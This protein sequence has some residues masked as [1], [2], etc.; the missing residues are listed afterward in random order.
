MQVH[1]LNFDIL[2]LI[3][4]LGQRRFKSQTGGPKTWWFN[5]LHRRQRHS[6]YDFKGSKR[7]PLARQQKYPKFQAGDCAVT[8]NLRQ[9][10][11]MCGIHACYVFQ[12]FP[13]TK[14]RK[15]FDLK[16]KS[17]LKVIQRL[18]NSSWSVTLSH[19]EMRMFNTWDY[20]L[21]QGVLNFWAPTCFI[22][23][24]WAKSLASSK[25]SVKS[26]STQNIFN[27]LQIMWPHPEYFLPADYHEVRSW[28]QTLENFNDFLLMPLKG[29]STQTN[30]EKC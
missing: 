30:C 26:L 25:W 21:W 22:L 13:T 20:T 17:S 11:Q 6:C 9:T 2:F 18:Q 10:T 8:N 12:V 5:C 29:T 7:V 15:T 19:P 23:T 3:S 16:K 4:V 14:M 1:L 28:I 27:S 24:A